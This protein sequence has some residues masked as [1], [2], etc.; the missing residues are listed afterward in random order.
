MITASINVNKID[1]L[2][3]VKGEKGIYCNLVLFETPSSAY[4]DYMI[5]QDM[6]KGEREAGKESPILG[7]A[8]IFKPKNAEPLPEEPGAV[9]K[10]DKVVGKVVDE[11]GDAI[12][13]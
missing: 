6:S 5:K 1:K 9:Q 11:D 3:L 7:N 12:P 8:K 4:G 10:R 13:F 2:R